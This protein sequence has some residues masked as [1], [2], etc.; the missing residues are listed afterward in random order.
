MARESLNF[1]LY[2]NLSVQENPVECCFFWRKNGVW[3]VS[4]GH[5]LDVW[6]AQSDLE[7]FYGVI[8]GEKSLVT[9][10]QFMYSLF[11]KCPL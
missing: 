9:V 8:L 7:L 10:I 6:M 11:S 3:R 5:L 1:M 4:I 2:Q